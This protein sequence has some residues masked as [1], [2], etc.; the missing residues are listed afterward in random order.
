MSDA[1]SNK[2][3][4]AGVQSGIGIA[5]GAKTGAGLLSVNVSGIN[6]DMLAARDIT[7]AANDGVAFIRAGQTWVV[8]AR[9]GTAATTPPI[10]AVPIA[11]PPKPASVSGS[12]TITPL[13]TR[14]RQD[15]RWRT[16]NDDVYQGEYGSNGN[17][18]G[19]AF[20]GNAPRSLAGA[21]VTSATVQLR[22]KDAGGLATAQP[23]T[24]RLVTERVRPVG[25]P[26][27]TSTTAAPSLA[28]SE[29]ASFDIPTAWAQAMVDGTAGGLAVYEAD[30]APYMI[31]DGRGSYSPS[32]ALTIRYTRT[33]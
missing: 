5:N 8:V 25:A 31:M 20:Y 17:H 13:E 33:I 14:S 23:L 24:L 1:A 26:T 10:D 15:T 12:T 21:T 7:F 16:D 6:V 4:L 32:F 2:V 19:A 3:S 28:W 11:P 22:R 29:V 30:G 27:L 9:L 18:V